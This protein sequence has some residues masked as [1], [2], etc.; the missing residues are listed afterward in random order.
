M[1]KTS[2]NARDARS[3]IILAG[4]VILAVLFLAAVLL[5]TP[6][7]PAD[8]QNFAILVGAI[9][10][11]N[12]TQSALD[13]PSAHGAE[14]AVQEINERGGIDGRPVRL[15]LY[16]GQTNTSRISEMAA[17][18]IHQ[19][20]VTAIIG[21]SDSDMVLPAAQTAAASGTVFITSGATSPL[22][23]HEVPN[24]LFLACFG[25]NTQA[26]AGAEYA[27]NELDARTAFLVTDDSMQYARLLSHYFTQRF[28]VIGG[29]IAGNISYAG[30]SVDYSAPVEA[31]KKLTPQPDLIYLSCGPDD[32]G[33]LAHAIRNAGI[34][35][36]VMGGDSF[37]TPGSAAAVAAD[38]GVVYYTTHADIS[39]SSAD[40]AMPAFIDRYERA[41]GQK[42]TAF[43]GLGY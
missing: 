21:M 11:L 7:H 13:I 2:S 17:R 23:S 39:S 15:I 28:T 18:L 37:D 34:T 35:A 19:D 9:Y 25:D 38:G 10:N 6:A 14:L 20:H 40:P 32:C 30:G 22:L 4:P 36:P 5:T 41:F 27:R 26:A 1:K 29:T 33:P 31:I 24:Y 43:S 42:P 8:N 3:L 16:D 12:G